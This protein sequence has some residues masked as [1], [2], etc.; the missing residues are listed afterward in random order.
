MLP[1]EYIQRMR[2]LLGDEAE[3]FFASYRQPRSLGLRINPLKTDPQSLSARLPWPLQPIPWAQHGFYYPASAQPGKHP[4][5]AAGVYYLQ[6]PS[7]MAVAE[8]AA[9]QPGERVLDLCAAP[10]GKATQLISLMGDQG[11]LVANELYPDRAKALVENL[12]RWGARRALVTSAEP[13][14]LAARFGAWFDCVL[15]DAP[16]SGEGMFRKDPDAAV[17]WSVRHVQECAALQVDI[18]QSA[19][20]L[21][22]PGGRLVYSTCT[23]SPEENEQNIAQLLQSHPELELLPVKRHDN[24]RPG[25]A[26]PGPGA[27]VGLHDTARLWPHLLRGEGHFIALLQKRG[28]N[29]HER[30][31]QPQVGRFALSKPPAPLVEFAE[32][33]LRWQP[34]GP[35]IEYGDYIYQLP[36][37]EIPALDG[38]RVPRPGWPLGQLRK[39]RFIPGHGLALSCSRDSVQQSLDLAADSQEVLHYL[40]GLTLPADL[41]NGWT[42]VTV[43]GFSLGWGKVVNRV[44]KNHYPKGLRW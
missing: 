25:L 35:F 34:E 17:Y 19:V 8:V 1:K 37:M 31:R 29:E 23:F 39:G 22:A 3:A 9:P 30:Q 15:V 36:G 38:I 18:L 16:C 21:L 4:Y 10:G 26:L 43:D 42:L 13:A 28:D 20:R 11:L 5:H 44:L 7:A 2:T 6:D 41:P 32:Q 33:F 24:W 14:R 27:V 40:R 12:E